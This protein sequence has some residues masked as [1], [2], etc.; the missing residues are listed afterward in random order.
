MAENRRDG[1]IHSSCG[2][3]IGCDVWC[4]VRKLDRLNARPRFYCD[5]G[6]TVYSPKRQTEELGNGY[7]VIALSLILHRP[8]EWVN[9]KRR[10]A[11]KL[12]RQLRAGELMEIWTSR[13]RMDPSSSAKNSP[14]GS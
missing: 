1:E 4:S 10:K 8:G 7:A 6:T 9:T 13:Q 3:L 5:A 2:I 12:A 11:M 14:A